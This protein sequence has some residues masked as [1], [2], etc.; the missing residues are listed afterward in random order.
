[1]MFIYPTND[2]LHDL[3]L[4]FFLLLIGGSREEDEVMEYV[5]E[6]E[7]RE[8]EGGGRRREKEGGGRRMIFSRMTTCSRSFLLLIGGSREENEV[9]EYVGEGGRRE[10]KGWGEVDGGGGREM[11]FIYPTDFTRLWAPVLFVVDRRI[12]RRR[13]HVVCRRGRREGEEREVWGKEG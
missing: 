5:Q 1:M 2:I 10:S 8:K 9:M 6:G 3:V 4:Q 12:E 7:G 13:C 11:M